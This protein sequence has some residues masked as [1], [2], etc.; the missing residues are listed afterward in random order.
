VD[1]RLPAHSAPRAG[2]GADEAAL[3]RVQLARRPTGGPRTR[4]G[5]PGRA[6]R[7]AA[8]PPPSGDGE[9]LGALMRWRSAEAKRRRVPAFR[10]LTNAALEGV[11]AARPRDERELLDVKGLGPA[12]VAKYGA[13]LLDLVRGA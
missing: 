4:K 8:P 5:K 2:L 6:P 9:L 10:I 3:D 7:A 11:A 13:A 1:H 12:L